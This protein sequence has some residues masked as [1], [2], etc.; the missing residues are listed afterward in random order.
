METQLKMYSL[1]N[2]FPLMNL[3]S[4]AGCL[5][6]VQNQLDDWLFLECNI[7]LSIQFP[8]IPMIYSDLYSVY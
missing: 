7:V 5:E 8:S 2:L 4:L 1:A 6:Y 3:H